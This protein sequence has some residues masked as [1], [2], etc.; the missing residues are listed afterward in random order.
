MEYR[1]FR[2]RDISD[3]WWEE[4]LALMQVPSRIVRLPDNK[5]LDEIDNATL[6]MEM[7]KR[8][9]AVMKLPENGEPP[10]ALKS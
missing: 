2:G 1:Q 10:E 8:G 4:Q 5:P 6:V 3:A 7:I 9:F